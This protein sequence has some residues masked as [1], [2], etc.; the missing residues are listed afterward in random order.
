MTTAACGGLSYK[1]GFRAAAIVC[2][3]TSGVEKGVER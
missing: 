1:K 2:A 3:E